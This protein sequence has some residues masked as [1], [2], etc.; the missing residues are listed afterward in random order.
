MASAISGS[1]SA[2]ERCIGEIAALGMGEDCTKV[3]IW[4]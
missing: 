4:K 2:S 1:V 3:E